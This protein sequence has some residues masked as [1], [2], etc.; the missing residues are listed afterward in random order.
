MEATL[1]HTGRHR[2]RMTR[3]VEAIYTQGVLKPLQDP[4]LREG[5]RVRLALV[6]EDILEETF[7]LLSDKQDQ[8]EKLLRELE[9]EITLHR[10]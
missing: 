10:Q 8:V 9:D 4:G 3:I 1:H 6:E 2:T 7:G 5:Q